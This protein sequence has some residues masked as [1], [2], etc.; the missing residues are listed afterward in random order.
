MLRTIFSLMLVL[1]ALAP[2]VA[3][4]WIPVSVGVE[5]PASAGDLVGS[6]CADVVGEFFVW[7]VGGIAINTVV[8]VDGETIVDRWDYASYHGHFVSK[9]PLA[10]GLACAHVTGTEVRPCV[11]VSGVPYYPP[12]CGEE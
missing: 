2:P 6:Y 5:A 8:T 11:I 7:T 12:T 3:S 1:L 10:T 4:D 9:I